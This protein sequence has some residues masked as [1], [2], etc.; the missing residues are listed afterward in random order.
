VADPA[1]PLVTLLQRGF[2]DHQAGRLAQAEAAYRQ[3]LAVQPAN[4]DALHFLGLIAHQCGNNQAAAEHI[5]RAIAS[6][7]SNANFY[8]NLGLILS[9]LGRPADAEA[10]LR[11]A[12]RLRPKFPEA[13]NSLGIALYALG[14][15]AEA[16][17]SYRKALRLKPDFADAFNNLG[18]TLSALGRP[19]DAE[20]SYRQ[21]LRLNPA[22]ADAHANLGIV[23][24]AQ[25]RP[26]EAEGSYREALRLRPEFPAALNNLGATLTMLGRAGE[27][28]ACFREVVR[29]RPDFADAHS[30]LAVA[31]CDLRRHADAQA[32][33]R[34]AI[35]LTPNYA[36]AHCNLGMA[37]FDLRRLDEA[38][39]SYRRALSLNPALSQ[40][41]MN[42]S[43][44]LLITG[45][46]E[47]GW[48]EHEWRWKTRNMAP[49]R[50]DFAVPLWVGEPVGGQTILLHAE[51]GLGDTLQFCRY[52]RLIESGAA[53]VLEVQA[54][55]A[56]L[57][58][59]MPGIAQVAVRGQA[60]PPFDLHCPLLSLPRAFGTTLATIPDKPYLAADPAEAT[61][62]RE[63]LANLPGL[64][65]G[66]VWA[67]EPRTGAPELAAIDARRSMALST[68][69]PLAE[70]EGVSFVSL[71]KGKPAAQAAGPPAGMTLTDL[72][73]DVHDFADTAALIENLD[74][75]IC[76]DTSVAHLAGGMGKPVW[77]LNRFDTCWRWLLDRDDSPWYPTLR[78]FRQPSP[79]DWLAV[80]ARVRD[81]LQRLAT[82]DLDQL[83]PQF[84]RTVGP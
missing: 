54:P 5:G 80:V 77:L 60:L 56:R 84:L 74:L 40:A 35:R 44:A 10:N 23:L 51:Q 13:L 69:A 50:R 41:H 76:V 6:N 78:Q 7:S 34:A 58:S 22:F 68:L 73:A 20:A 27:A 14:R 72:T 71:Q 64:K 57:V 9:Q 43:S 49:G 4:A 26:A 46:F 83:R 79:G 3:I 2:A 30:N 70:V 29:L 67:G 63:R 65:I 53:V 48:S 32:S 82:G 15:A 36:D 24:A 16:E 42:L 1:S 8:C 18:V 37:L 59:R 39:A 19:G 47:E 61:S 31:L 66:L 17:E 21:A 75:V 11:T 12:L 62:W 28:E 38:E 55:L 52:A 45:R 33:A 81:A 25:D